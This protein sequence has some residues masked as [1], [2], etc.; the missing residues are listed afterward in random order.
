MMMVTFNKD[1]SFFFGR[2]D[3]RA[4]SRAGQALRAAL[5]TSTK[6]QLYLLCLG[7]SLLLE[8]ILHIASRKIARSTL[9]AQ[10]SS[11]DLRST[12][13]EKFLFQKDFCFIVL[14]AG[15]ILSLIK[16]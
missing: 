2:K 4:A 10:L 14:I 13:L 9:K 5:I 1:L 6:K 11:T 15:D 8:S 3:G 12:K 16:F 7:P